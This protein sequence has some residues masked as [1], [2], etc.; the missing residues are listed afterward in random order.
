MNLFKSCSLLLTALVATSTSAF[1]KAP[2][3]RADKWGKVVCEAVSQAEALKF[4]KNSISE[5]GTPKG[6]LS[7][8]LPLKISVVESGGL[9]DETGKTSFLMEAQ[10]VDSPIVTEACK[11]TY[12]DGSA[13]RSFEPAGQ[14]NAYSDTA[15]GFVDMDVTFMN[16]SENRVA[17]TD[18]FI[19]LAVS[20]K[21]RTQWTV[22]MSELHE[23]GE[24][25]VSKCHI[26]L[27]KK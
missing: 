26:E 27:P 8:S 21:A 3:N 15:S 22:E 17:E 7:C 13:S 16:L 2:E 6:T 18:D 24:A 1:A 11:V 19:A 14:G 12:F 20:R 23:G 25:I 4:A 5:N 9:M 10:T